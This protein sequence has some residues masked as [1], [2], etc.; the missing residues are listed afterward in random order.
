[1]KYDIVVTYTKYRYVNYTAQTF[2]SFELPC[3]LEADSI[4]LT[5]K[6]ASGIG[7]VLFSR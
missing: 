1:M 3:L 6:H 7:R 5:V 2:C 4:P